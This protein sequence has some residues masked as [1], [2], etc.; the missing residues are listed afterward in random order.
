V[1][2]GITT[3]TFGNLSAT[4]TILTATTFRMSLSVGGV[5]QATQDFTGTPLSEV[6]FGFRANPIEGG[7]IQMDNFTLPD[8]IPEPSV[9]LSAAIGILGLTFLRRR[10]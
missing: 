8:T 3:G 5:E 1:N 6:S 7:T 4:Y 9:A 2:A 10:R